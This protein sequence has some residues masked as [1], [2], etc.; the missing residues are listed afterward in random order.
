MLCKWSRIARNLVGWA[1]FTLHHFL[2]SHW[3]G[4]ARRRFS[5]GGGYEETTC[6]HQAGNGRSVPCS[7]Q[8]T[9]PWQGNRNAAW[10]CWIG[11]G[12]LAFCLTMSRPSSGGVGSS[13]PA[14]VRG[15]WAGVGPLKVNFLLGPSQTIAFLSG[16]MGCNKETQGTYRPKFVGCLLSSF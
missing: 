1:Y 14:S 16:Y 6:L 2:K 8:S 12:W 11:D 3:G 9:L 13:L 15:G 5:S 7:A 10:F 4:A